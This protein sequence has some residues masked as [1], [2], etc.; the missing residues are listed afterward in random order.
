MLFLH[1]HEGIKPLGV[2]GK[3]LHG[4]GESGLFISSAE[5]NPYAKPFKP[6][7]WALGDLGPLEVYSRNWYFLLS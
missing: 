7:P 4:R 6:A 5:R 1:V 3:N 2:W